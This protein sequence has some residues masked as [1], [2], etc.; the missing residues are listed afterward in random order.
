MAVEV[1][2]TRHT[3]YEVH[4]TKH[5]PYYPP[6]NDVAMVPTIAQHGMHTVLLPC[7]APAMVLYAYTAHAHRNAPLMLSCLCYTCHCHNLCLTQP[8]SPLSLALT[9]NLLALVGP[10][11]W[12]FVVMVLLMTEILQLVTQSCTQPALTLAMYSRDRGFCL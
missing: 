10:F 11:Y 2:I 5:T 8:P 3:P 6:C 1:H 12:W 4:I 7:H 9:W